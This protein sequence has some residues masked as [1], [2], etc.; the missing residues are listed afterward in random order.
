MPDV[1]LVPNVGPESLSAAFEDE[2][3]DLAVAVRV[4]EGGEVLG[5]GEGGGRGEGGGGA[6]VDADLPSVN[7][8]DAAIVSLGGDDAGEAPSGELMK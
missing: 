2:W 3:L 6:M 4:S 5:V 8:G 1:A 7:G